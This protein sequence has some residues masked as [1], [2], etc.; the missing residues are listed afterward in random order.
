MDTDKIFIYYAI[1]S[2]VALTLKVLFLFRVSTETALT[3]S[4]IFLCLVIVIQNASEFMGY[5]FLPYDLD[6]TKKIVDVYMICSYYLGGALLYFSLLLTGY[7]NKVLSQVI[8]GIPTIFTLMHFNGMLVSD[9]EYNGYALIRVPM[10]LYILFEVYIV[11]CSVAA[12]YFLTKTALNKEIETLVSDRCK[13]GLVAILPF[14]AVIITIVVLMHLGNPI[15]SAVILPMAGVVFLLIT[16][17]ASNRSTKEVY[18]VADPLMNTQA[19]MAE[20]VEHLEKSMIIR[21]L[22]ENNGI[23]QDAAEQLGIHASTLTKKIQKY[24][25]E[26]EAELAKQLAPAEQAE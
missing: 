6:T 26:K 3:R 10:D 21:A 5:M 18:D 8:W 9:Y 12:I 17:K 13:L 7:Q 1:P 25:L 24:G 11:S 16:M 15:S 23:K 14:A 2:V 4:F 22:N 19:T 20:R